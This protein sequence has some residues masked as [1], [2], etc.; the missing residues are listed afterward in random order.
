MTSTGGTDKLDKQGWR[1]IAVATA[2]L[3]LFAVLSS[4]AITL[5]A[6]YVASGEII[7]PIGIYLAIGVPALVAPLASFMNISL[8]YRLQIANQRLQALSE[9]DSLT[10]TLNRRR[11]ME[12]AERELVLAAR[13]CY[14]TSVVLIDFD[15]FKQVNDKYGH[16]AG[17]QALVQTI[18]VIKSMV[19]DSDVLA[20]FGGEEFILLLPHTA[21]EGAQSLAQRMLEAIAE[22]P[23]ELETKE[24]MITVSA[25]SVTCETSTT[26]LDV[27]TSKADE[28]LYASKQNGRNQCTS[29]TLASRITHLR[30]A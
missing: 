20:R 8:S 25:G 9:T 22:N 14:P 10:D 11:F 13:H 19:R 4:L 3:T 6:G 23:I 28:L 5:L 29:A 30:Q 27:M 16:A 24:L 18:Q 1:A 12:V 2:R 15:D 17:D 7:A 26:P 21:R